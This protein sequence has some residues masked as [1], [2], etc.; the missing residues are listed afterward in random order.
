LGKNSS[1]T[2]LFYGFASVRRGGIFW[3]EAQEVML[4]QDNLRAPC[5]HPGM[6]PS[7]VAAWGPPWVT[8]LL[9]HHLLGLFPKNK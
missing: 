8:L 4:Q 9:Q 2:P 6:L 5:G 3:K 1:G 7:W